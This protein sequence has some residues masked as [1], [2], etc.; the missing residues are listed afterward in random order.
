MDQQEKH[1]QFAQADERQEQHSNRKKRAAYFDLSSFEND[2]VGD[3]CALAN[4]N[5]LSDRDVRAKLGSRM[6]FGRRVN[7]NVADDLS[8]GTRTACV[9]VRA[10]CQMSRSLR[11]QL[12][13][14]KL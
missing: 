1:T 4:D 11:S 9:S 13:E 10:R 14:Q 8:T 5:V 7:E 12:L 3:A 6:N 2:T